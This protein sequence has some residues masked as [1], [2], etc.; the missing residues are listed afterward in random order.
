M[1]I[2][3]DAG[4]LWEMASTA[5]QAISGK[6]FRPEYECLY[7]RVSEESGSPVM[8][9]MGKDSGI[10]IA[11]ATDK[12]I[13]VEDGEALIPAK[14][15]LAFTKLMKGDVTLEVDGKLRCTMKCGAKKTSIS[16]MDPADF[17][18]EFTAMEEPRMV[19]MGGAEFEKAVASTLHCVSTDNG[20]MVL[21]GVNFAFDG[22]RG[23]CEATGLDGF[24]MAISRIPAE[25][26]ETFNV[27]IPASMAKLIAKI[28]KGGED[29]S[30]RFGN[31]VVIV[32]DYDTSIE[33][34]LL[35]GEYMDVHKI[36][37]REGKMQARVNAGELLDAVKVAMVAADT[38]KSLV[39]MNF[40]SDSAIHVTANSE[41]SAAATDVYC[42]RIGEMDGGAVSIA[43]NGKYVEEALK[44]GMDYAGEV[45]LLANTPSSP[46]AILP[47]DRDDYYQL[48]L[49]VRTFNN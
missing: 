25:T 31:G 22:E 14:L 7:I 43:F 28:I 9:V 37:F 47:V 44:A 46:M 8:T 41:V 16:G 36:A 27:T 6:P 12:I 1:K 45:T 42:D 10:A 48:V 4:L 49:P 30:F 3:I 18:A 21:T 2:Q 19:K 24:R 17:P 20:R 26:N 38:N 40:E 35:A 32:D 11:R 33:A 39:L 15:L 34:S 29:V 23:F 5:A 13:A